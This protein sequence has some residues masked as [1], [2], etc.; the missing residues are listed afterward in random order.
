MSV[1]REL[2]RGS[3]R[4]RIAW[5]PA[6]LIGLID[7]F[8]QAGSLIDRIQITHSTLEIKLEPIDSCRYTTAPLASTAW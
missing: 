6:C 5:L 4:L 3:L 2:R 7:W 1:K 8:A